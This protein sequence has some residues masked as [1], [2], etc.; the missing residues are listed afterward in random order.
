MA[1]VTEVQERMATLNTQLRFGRHQQALIEAYKFRTFL[2]LG[3]VRSQEAKSA[4]VRV[5]RAIKALEGQRLT[6]IQKLVNLIVRTVKS[7]LNPTD[8]KFDGDSL[9]D[10]VDEPSPT[11]EQPK[12][13][14]EQEE[15]VL[16]PSGRQTAIREKP[17]GETPL[18]EEPLGD[19]T[20]GW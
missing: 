20:P 15:P 1:G 2:Q 18:G 6:G 10:R 17:L 11:S 12:V 3:G 16:S 14:V 8:E 4:L 5:E 9:L 19:S 7:S 13:E